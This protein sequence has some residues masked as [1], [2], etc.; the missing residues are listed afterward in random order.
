MH[1]FAWNTPA[2]LHFRAS[3]G[4]RITVDFKQIF[5]EEEKNRPSTVENLSI[6]LHHLSMI[7][8]P[9]IARDSYSM[10]Y[11]F[12]STRLGI[13]C[14]KLCDAKLFFKMLYYVFYIVASTIKDNKCFQGS[15]IIV[16]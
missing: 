5:S 7:H 14:S 4:P 10:S 2:S 3:L 12:L 16:E 6:I 13:K 15:R 9:M 1:V 11:F 8:I